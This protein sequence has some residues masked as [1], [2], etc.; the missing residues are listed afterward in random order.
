MTLK[1]APW[2]EE[3]TFDWDD[4]NEDHI[5]RHHISVFEIEECFEGEHK[6]R[7]HKK[8][9]SEP[10]KYGDRYEVSGSTAGGRKLWMV[11]Q[12]LGGN[13]I[14]PITARVIVK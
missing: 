12:Y 4:E 13:L 7:P 5:W 3:P 11:I 8:S 14:R 6:I 10:E 9:T 2:G 1:F